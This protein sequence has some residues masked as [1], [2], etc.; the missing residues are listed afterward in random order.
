MEKT[1][2]DTKTKKRGLSV[3]T[4]GAS[5]AARKADM[6]SCIMT[7]AVDEGLIQINLVHRVRRFRAQPKQL[8]LGEKEFAQLGK[9]L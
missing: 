8:F 7:W 2:A 1:K 9:V 6:L 3:V 4:G 5:T